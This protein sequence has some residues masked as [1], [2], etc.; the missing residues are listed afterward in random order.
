MKKWLLF[1]LICLIAS[2]CDAQTPPGGY[3]P[4]VGGNTS[5]STGNPTTAN[6]I[7]P[8]QAP[9]NVKPDGYIYA[10]GTTTNTSPNFSSASQTC[11]AS[12]DTGKLAIVVNA[13]TG[14]YAYGTGLITV[15][16]CNGNAWVLSGN[17]SQSIPGTANWA[18]GSDATPG[19]TGGLIQAYQA[20]FAAFPTQ[21]KNLALPCGIMI[22]TAPPF[23]V[24]TPLNIWNDRPDISG[25]NAG[26]G[27]IFVLHPNI[28]STLLTNGGNLFY[29]IPNS[30]QPAGALVYAGNGGNQ[31]VQ[32]L[33]IVGLTG[34]IPGTAGKNFNFI[35]QFGMVDN[36]SIFGVSMTAGTLI[37]AQ[38]ASGEAK[39]TRLNF[40]G[41]GLGS[42]SGA[43]YIGV[44]MQGQGTNVVDK[45]IFQSAGFNPAVQCGSNANCYVNIYCSGCTSGVQTSASGAQ[46]TI[47]GSTLNTANGPAIS[48]GPGPDTFYVFG[49][50][51]I[52][53]TVASRTAIAINNAGSVM[54]L[55]GSTVSSGTA[56][57]NVTGSGQ[58]NDRAGNTFSSVLTQFGGKYVPIG[59]GSVATNSAS[60]ATNFGVN[61]GATPIVAA[62]PGTATYDVKIGFRVVTAGVGCSTN[63]T[64]N[65]VLSWT[66][67]G[68]AQATGSGGVPALATLTAVNN[69]TVG[70]SSVYSSVPIHA[71]INTAINFTT[72]SV[73]GTCATSQ[74]QYVVD[75]SNI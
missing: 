64:V 36:V 9:Y 66:A 41:V 60:A 51:L 3:G 71:D 75:F 62:S 32:H 1:F 54:D 17:A 58:L 4:S 29:T 74:P 33:Q 68:A 55:S 40:Q 53:A 45:S 35:N 8:T 34:N 16:G 48:D 28:S 59:G 65:G 11:S 43:A 19:G 21:T 30:N 63:G 24:P 25:C 47:V 69:S 46:V 61:I 27:T 39:G 49:N 70:T 38:F 50:P 44:L 67:G 13:S 15:T 12:R 5:S 42:G 7:D 22:L 10:D 73:P 37:F 56:G 20:T 52:G 14:A 72:T 31:T 18:I 6:M 2:I 26:T 57:F 23:Q